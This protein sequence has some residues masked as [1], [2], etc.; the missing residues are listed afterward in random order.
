MLAQCL[1]QCVCIQTSLG[2]NLCKYYRP[3]LYLKP[4]LRVDGAINCMSICFYANHTG[5]WSHH[6]ANGR[7]CSSKVVHKRVFLR[8]I[9]HL[10]DGCHFSAMKGFVRRK[11]QQTKQDSMPT[12]IYSASLLLR[13]TKEERK[14]PDIS[15]VTRGNC[16]EHASQWKVNSS[17]CVAH[18]SPFS[19]PDA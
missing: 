8:D 12:V 9:P 3:H 13:V 6:S 17:G 2:T 19:C 18:R 10:L 15:P 11:K 16:W 14:V 5:K 7:C 1:K 4:H